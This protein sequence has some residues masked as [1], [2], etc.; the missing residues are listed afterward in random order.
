[1]YPH[2]SVHASRRN[3]H[4]SRFKLPR[5]KARGALGGISLVLPGTFPIRSTYAAPQLHH[6]VRIGEGDP[7]ISGDLCCT[8]R[9]DGHAHVAQH[10]SVRAHLATFVG[11]GHGVGGTSDGDESTLLAPFPRFLSFQTRVRASQ[12]LAFVSWTP[13]QCVLA[14]LA[15]AESRSKLRHRHGEGPMATDHE[16]TECHSYHNESD[17]NVCHGTMAKGWRGDVMGKMDE[18]VVERE[19]KDVGGTWTPRMKGT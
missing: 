11:G 4:V 1:M 5:G 19:V 17:T 12:Q 3:G 10:R 14:A 16:P 2:S 6:A 8:Q 13:I 9:T 7:R 15:A 18:D